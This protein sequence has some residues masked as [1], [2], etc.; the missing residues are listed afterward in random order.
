MCLAYLTLRSVA[1]PPLGLSPIRRQPP[2]ASGSLAARS[3]KGKY[4]IY[5]IQPRLSNPFPLVCF[6]LLL[7]HGHPNPTA[8]LSTHSTLLHC[9]TLPLNFT[10]F[11][12]LSYRSLKLP[13]SHLTSF[14]VTSPKGLSP[15][16]Q[17]Q[18]AR[19]AQKK[20]LHHPPIIVKSACSNFHI[21]S[22]SAGRQPLRALPA[23]CQHAVIVCVC[24]YDYN[25]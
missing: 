19:Q 15:L 21:S 23:S 18:P 25:N 10:A 4:V 20:M 6:I 11:L 8:L 5:T 12:P 24:Y 2:F 14:S 13:S 17:C 1:D 3:R 16:R 9:P 22:V 7:A